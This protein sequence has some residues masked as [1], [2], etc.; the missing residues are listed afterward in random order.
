MAKLP[1]I[2]QNMQ[3]GQMKRLAEGGDATDDQQT[4]DPSVI[5]KIP[6]QKTTLDTAETLTPTTS[7]V[8]TG[9]EVAS[10]A[11]GVSPTVNVTSADYSNL[12]VSKPQAVAA[13][14][15]RASCRERV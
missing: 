3:Q 14:I 4:F 6:E 1:K 2:I 9:E 13:E 8:Q 7:S 10:P 11:L 15:G 5:S 12:N